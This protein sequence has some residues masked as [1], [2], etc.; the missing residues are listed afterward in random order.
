M[1]TWVHRPISSALAHADGQAAGLT[2]AS[3]A[4]TRRRTSGVPSLSDHVQVNDHFLPRPGIMPDGV[5]NE[6]FSSVSCVGTNEALLRD[7]RRMCALRRRVHRQMWRT[8]LHRELG[9]F[10]TRL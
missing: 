4:K 3:C 8:D 7:P 10:G 9:C 6:I 2:W 1:S 5:V